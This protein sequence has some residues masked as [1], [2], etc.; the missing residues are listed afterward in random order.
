MFFGKDKA[1]AQ[2]ADNPADNNVVDFGA[3]KGA[4]IFEVGTPEFEERVIKASMQVPVIAY[5]TA[6]WCGPCKQ[7]G[8]ILDAAVQAVGGEVIMAKINL[9]ENQELAQALRIQSV[10][11]VFGFFQGRPVDAFQGAVPDSKV[12]EFITKLVQAARAAQPDA[13]DIPE[14]LKGAA[15]ALAAQDLQTAQGVYLQI[16]QQ[17][18]TNAKA[19]AGLVRVMIAAGELGQAQDMIENAPE[20]MAKDSAIAEVKTALELAQNCPDDGILQGLLGAVESNPEDHQARFDLAVAQFAAGA[21]EEA[22]DQLL[23]IV[24]RNRE[25]NEEEARKQLLK[26][27]EAMGHS[28]PLTVAARKKLSSLLFS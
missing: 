19:Y 17:E 15:E 14:A 24:E 1:P 22:I 25:W 5:F 11:T 20:E 26:F 23:Y 18:E 28:D 16:L 6:P 13:I 12:K 27:F 4:T 7:L 2:P 3:T 8:P 10:P 9:D 21:R